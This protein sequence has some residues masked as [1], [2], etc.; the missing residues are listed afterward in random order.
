MK[1]EIINGPNLNLLGVREPEIYGKSTLKEIERK[2]VEALS[3]IEVELQFWQT[4][5]EGEII[6]LLHSA[7][8]ERE[9]TGI[10]LNAG[11]YSHYSIAIAD[12]IS[13][14]NIPVIEIHLTN[15]L[16]RE[17]FRHSSVIGKVCKGRIEGFGWFGY[18]LAALCLTRNEND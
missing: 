6:N 12:A 13:S 1:I 15:T 9:A 18:V 7:K 3:D 5:S 14:I 4:N 8:S 2:V 16:S 17:I 10:I 11:A